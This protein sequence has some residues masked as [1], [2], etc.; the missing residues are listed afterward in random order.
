[1]NCLC[2]QIL[3]RPDH[4]PDRN[5]RQME[6]K[7]QSIGLWEVDEEKGAPSMV[8]RVSK[9][10][11]GLRRPLTGLLEAC[12]SGAGIINLEVC[13]CVWVGVWVGRCRCAGVWVGVYGCVCVC[14]CVW[15]GVCA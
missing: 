8:L 13:V 1:M 14:V 15:V 5:P 3:I 10:K 6:L 4:K 11:R 2:G 9:E 12:C 7:P